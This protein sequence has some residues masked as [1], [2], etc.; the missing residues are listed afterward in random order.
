ML[1]SKSIYLG[2]EI[3]EP[4]ECDYDS[5]AYLGLKCP[6]CNNAVF[7]VKPHTRKL[8]KKE[9]L[10]PGHFSHFVGG[11]D[12]EAKSVT[13][14]GR[15]DIEAVKQLARNQRLKIYNTRLWHLLKS[16]RNIDRTT[17]VAMRKKYGSKWL[18]RLARLVQ[19]EI[20]ANSVELKKRMTELLDPSQKEVVLDTL[21]ASEDFFGKSINTAGSVSQIEDQ[22]EYLAQCDLRIHRQISSEILDFLSTPSGTEALN[23][24]LEISLAY[25]NGYTREHLS[26]EGIKEFSPSDFTGFVSGLVGGTQWLKH[27]GDE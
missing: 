7:L 8:A 1:Y 23:R 19:A 20:K 17:L 9:A 2:G 5:Y 22:A 14:K 3:I 12:C 26:I 16:D 6:F 4:D 15:Q 11:G 24:F 10:V 25:L 27:L 21:I 13:S 18:D